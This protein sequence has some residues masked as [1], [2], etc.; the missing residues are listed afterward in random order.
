ML[1]KNQN[2]CHKSKFTRKHKFWSEI[3]I[4]QFEPIM[5]KCAEFINFVN[6]KKCAE[7][8]IFLVYIQM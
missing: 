5:Q 1:V 6:C 2:F 3:D 8:R 7:L 4:L